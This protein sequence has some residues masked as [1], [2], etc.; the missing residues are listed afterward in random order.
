MFIGCGIFFVWA[1]SELGFTHKYYM[2]LD[3]INREFQHSAK[4]FLWVL[5]PVMINILYGNP[6]VLYPIGSM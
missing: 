3:I 1:S 5:Y 6:K 2:D 4:A